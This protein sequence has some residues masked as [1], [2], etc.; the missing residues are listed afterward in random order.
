MVTFHNQ[1]DIEASPEAVFDELSD[2][3]HEQRWSDKLKSVELLTPGP[4]EVGSRLRAK[5]SGAP[6]NEVVYREYDRPRRWTTESRSWMLV[7]E[8]LLEV[9]PTATGSRLLST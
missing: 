8:V 1:V 3:R 7:V 6:E 9:E 2:V 4:I 5:W